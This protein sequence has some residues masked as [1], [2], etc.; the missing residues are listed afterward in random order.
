MTSIGAANLV[1][2]LRARA[3]DT[4]DRTVFTFLRDGVT[5]AETVTFG[6]LDRRARETA[7]WLQPRFPAGE[8]ALLLYPPGIEFV[9]AFLGCV[10]AG[11][12]AVPAY[13]PRG[14]DIDPRIR[15]M[16]AHHVGVG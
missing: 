10:Y 2:L 8:R 6:E 14:R 13:P 3:A 16:A 12:V 4:P 15:A 7:A 11:L 5:P 1:D 9:V